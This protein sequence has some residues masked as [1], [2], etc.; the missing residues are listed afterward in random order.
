MDSRFRMGSMGSVVGEKITRAIERAREQSI[1]FIICTASG[2]ARMQEG[3]LSLMQ[4]SKTSMTIERHYESGG[5][6]ITVMTQP[7][8][9]SVTARFAAMGDDNGG[10]RRQ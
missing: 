7:T 4:M 3:V 9:S 10:E 8:T 5:L 1:P 2:G 6:M